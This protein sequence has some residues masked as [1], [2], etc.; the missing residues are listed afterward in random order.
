[1]KKKYTSLL[2]C[3]LTIFFLIEIFNNTEIIL[4][5]F[6]E[7]TIIWFKNIVPNTFL[8]FII[9]DILNNYH[10]TK[11]ISLIMGNFIQK[12]FKL[13]KESSYTIVMSILSGFPSNSKLIKELLDDNQITINDAN[14]LLTFTHFSNPLFVISTIG[15]SFLNNKKIGIIILIVHY[16]TN[17]IVGLLFRNIYYE[18][19]DNNNISKTKSLS[20]IPLL[21][22]SILNTVNT[23]FTI[24]GIIIF[25]FI[26]TT[27]I[28]Y[29]FNLNPFHRMLIN[30]LLEIT[31]GLKKLSLLNINVIIKA[32]ISTFFI[33][34]G[35]LSIHMQVMSILENYNINYGI[36][37]LS[38]ILHASIS[39]L[40]V[41]LFLTYI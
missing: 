28:N 13:P 11:Y 37:F 16:L 25:F 24:Y 10:F 26:I 35:G 22:N 33:S 18:K 12:V 14:K 17:F 36:Y 3:A 21:K 8:L 40:I 23:L 9:T 34:F 32:T 20:F 4:N 39:S 29:K 41:Y 1:M 31:N 15:I 2:I 38:R 19:K 5:A 27:I 30:G 7:G 6:F